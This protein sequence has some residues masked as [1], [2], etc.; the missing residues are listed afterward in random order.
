MM[1]KKSLAI[2]WEAMRPRKWLWLFSFLVHA[3]FFASNDVLMPF[4]ISR[5]VD[6]LTSIDGKVL[7]DFY[8]FL[9]L[10]G[11]LHLVQTVLGRIGIYTW[12]Y[13]LT[14][15]LMSI[16][17]KSFSVTLT[18]GS[19]FFSN[20][21][22]GSL[23]TKFNRFTRSFDTIATASM[24]DLNALLVSVVFPF[25]ILVF[26]QPTIAL[27]L[28]GWSAFFA[29]SLLY[30]HRKKI[31]RARKVA[32]Y[33]SKMT[34]AFADVVTNALSVKMFARFSKEYSAF[35]KLGLKRIE[36][37]FR[38]MVFAD[39]IRVY[40]VFFI[41]LLELAVFYFSAKFAIEGTLSI[42]NVLLIQ[43]YIR[44]LIDG[45]WEFGKLVEK[46]EE[47][48][49]DASEMT[50]IYDLEP[51]V[52]DAAEPKLLNNIQG[53]IEF[54]SVNFT[55]PGDNEQP[56][57]QNLQ[58]LIPVGQKVGLVGPSGGGK[59]TFTKLLLRFMD[60]DTGEITL[61]GQNIAEVAQD[62]LRNNIAY[63]PQEPLLFHRSIYDNIAYGNPDASREEV[64]RAAKL[65]HADEFIAKLPAGYETLVGER[66]V[67]LS[68]GQK[69]RVAIARAMLKQAP[70]LVLDEA[71]SALDSKSEKYI[72]S[73][74][75]NLMKKRTTIVIAH[76]LST[77]RKLDRILV[78]KD[79]QIV[80]DGTHKELLARNGLYAELWAHQQGDFLKE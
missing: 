72:T 25:F 10:W 69:Q 23:V 16:D 77:I 34:G 27:I 39:F 47:A 60:I 9:W 51:A 56:V 58:L 36:A 79:G 62:D 46:L 8:G 68:G 38:N 24:F 15:T 43:L 48:L 70:V 4:L 71:T 59:T 57:F 13:V 66:G 41:I 73:A 12:F 19:D 22:T 76:R 21:F 35:Q 5:F 32:A 20:N 7:S 74:L 28:L 29:W 63:V 45:L 67:K 50:E 52:K 55:Y 61:D 80:E 33:D 2:Y 42:G 17:L 78:I 37:R 64:L 31:P 65:A 3:I 40:K 53:R 11:G 54:S 18:H 1:L 26:I 30:L 6:A 14:R 49:A 44:L 75:D